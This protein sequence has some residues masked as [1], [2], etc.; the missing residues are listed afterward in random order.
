[1]VNTEIFPA[2]CDGLVFCLFSWLNS[3]TSGFFVSLI[4]IG[5]VIVIFMATIN[6]G[7]A[8]AFGF[9]GGVLLLASILL[10]TA[11]LI[12]ATIS[13][14]SALLGASGIITMIVNER[15]SG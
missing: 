2:T 9:S 13:I 6:A 15:R 5:V 10:S 4:L 3:I 8:R 11:G 14:F 7:V 1:M 12:P